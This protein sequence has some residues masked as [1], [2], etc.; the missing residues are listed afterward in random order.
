MDR[1]GLSDTW[2]PRNLKLWTISTQSP[3]LKM[4]E[5]SDLH[6]LQ[7]RIASFVFFVINAR[8]FAGHQWASF[9]TLSWYV[10]PKMRP[11]TVSSA[12]FIME[13]EVWEDIRMHVMCVM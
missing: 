1:D 8:L 7:S 4:G 2:Q 9:G 12:I 6:F 5:W 10:L 3:L 13:L 11:N